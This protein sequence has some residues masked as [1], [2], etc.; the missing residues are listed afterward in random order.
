MDITCLSGVIA[1]RDRTSIPSS[2]GRVILHTTTQPR[3]SRHIAVN[4]AGRN[5]QVTMVYN[6]SALRGMVAAEGASGDREQASV[7]DVA[8]V[9]DTAASKTTVVINHARDYVR[10]PIIQD[11]T[12]MFDFRAGSATTR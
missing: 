4:S 3:D 12:S 9:L 8:Y 10:L 6:S 11:A 7:R 2:R 5:V 1:V